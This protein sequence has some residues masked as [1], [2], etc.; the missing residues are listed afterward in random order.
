MSKRSLRKKRHTT[1]RNTN[2]TFKQRVAVGS[3]HAK[4]IRGEINYN[5]VPQ[6]MRS[7]PAE[8]PATNQEELEEFLTPD[9]E[10]GEGCTHHE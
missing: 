2:L 8:I 6:W 5:D 3:T 4:L 9:H 10:H 7:A 1:T